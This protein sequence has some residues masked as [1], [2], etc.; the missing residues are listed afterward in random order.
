M[1]PRVWIPFF[2]RQWRQRPVRTC[3]TLLS[4]VV[5]VMLVVLAFNTTIGIEQSMQ[6]ARNRVSAHILLAQKDRRQP[7]GIAENGFY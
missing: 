7:G 3:I 2:V 4:I 1:M 5:S 6:E